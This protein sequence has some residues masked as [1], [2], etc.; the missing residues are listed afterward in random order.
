MATVTTTLSIDKSLFE[1][2]EALADVLD[3]SRSKVFAMALEQFLQ[4]HEGKKLLEQLNGVYGGT[5]SQQ[6]RDVRATRAASWDR[7][8]NLVISQGDVFRLS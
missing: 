4:K 2:A 1:R 5:R 6:E 3:V 8:G 7:R